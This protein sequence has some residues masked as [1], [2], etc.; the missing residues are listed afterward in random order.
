[1]KCKMHLSNSR[2]GSFHVV[3]K[4]YLDTMLS[5]S[6]VTTAWRVLRLRIEKT[7]SRYE[8]KL[9]RNDTLT[10]NLETWVSRPK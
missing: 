2:H 6:L 7:A 8:G 1:M 4:I 3:F 9:S 5:G 10:S